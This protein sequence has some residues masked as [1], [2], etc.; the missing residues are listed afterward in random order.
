M[1]SDSGSQEYGDD[2]F[3][4]NAMAEGSDNTGFYLTQLEQNSQ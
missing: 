2:C 3:M 4:M 1:D